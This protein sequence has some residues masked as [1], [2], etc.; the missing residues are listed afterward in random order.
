MTAEPGNETVSRDHLQNGVLET[1]LGPQLVTAGLAYR[2]D[3]Y[4][5]NGDQVEV[6]TVT[7]PAAPE[8]GEVR[9]ADDASVTWEFHGRPS[10]DGIGAILATT[11]SLLT[12]Q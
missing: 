11:I 3:F 12:S 9:I 4:T 8:R 10:N 1:I 5:G 7:N 2:M 6:M